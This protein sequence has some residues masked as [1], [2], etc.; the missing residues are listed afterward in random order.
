[1]GCGCAGSVKTAV[2]NA[3]QN[4]AAQARQPRSD[5]RAV[6]LE[7]LTWIPPDRPNQP[8]VKPAE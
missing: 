2:Q 7:S 5:R 6:T 3:E 8:A 1:M 4:Q